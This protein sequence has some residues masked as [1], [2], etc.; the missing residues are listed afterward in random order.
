MDINSVNGQGGFALTPTNS[1]NS[2]LGQQ[3]FL[4]LLI[5]QL[6][7]QD[8][9]NP[10]D[11]TEFAAQLA[12]YS[13]LEQLVG[14]NEGIQSLQTSQDLMSANLTNSM[15]ASLTGKEV[16]ALTNQV[17]LSPEGNSEIQFRLSNQAEEVD[18]IIRDA[19]GIEIMRETIEGAP[20]GENTWTWDGKNGN[21]SRM[22]EGTYQVE[23]AA[24]NGDNAVGA[25]MYVDG[26]AGAVRYT[27]NG[28]FITVN[29]IDVPISDVEEVRAPSTKE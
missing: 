1:D 27:G 15:A 13:S 26:M 5:T 28:V 22:G 7:N 11:S 6:Q 10:M 4:Q 25:L 16:R 24:R 21:G 8:P 23:I 12:Q 14:V 29:N 20:S 3:E 19:S 9:I 18:I 17:Y 2:T